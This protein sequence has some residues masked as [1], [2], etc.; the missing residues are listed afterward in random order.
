[1]LDTCRITKPGVGEPTPD[2]VTLQMVRPAPVVVY[3]GPCRVPRRASGAST[4]SARA[5]DAAWQVG[6]FPLDLPFDDTDG[7]APG[8]TVEYLSSADDPSLV[9]RVFGVVEVAYQSQATARR[10]VLRAVTR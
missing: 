9:G 4:A 10:L 8:Q 1:M 5:G 7:V 3:E 2:P 6:S